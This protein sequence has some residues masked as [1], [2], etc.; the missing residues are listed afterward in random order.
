MNAREE[1]T[2]IASILAHCTGLPSDNPEDWDWCATTPKGERARI[3][4]IASESLEWSRSLAVRL[5]GA[6]DALPSVAAAQQKPDDALE[7]TCQAIRAKR[8]A[9]DETPRRRSG[10]EAR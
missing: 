7:D 5:R 8:T 2:K 4:A 3:L 9:N 6:V 10:K 1:L